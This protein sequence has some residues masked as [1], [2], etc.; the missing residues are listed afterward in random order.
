VSAALIVF[1]KHPTPGRAKTR[2]AAALG[3]EDAAAVYRA[4]AEELMRRSR[5]PA[6]RR[7][8]FFAPGTTPEEMG[9][10][11]PGEEWHA[12]RG[13]DLGERIHLAFEAAFAAGA[14]RAA[15]VGS[16]LPWIGEREVLEAL[17]ALDSSD[18][19]VGPSRDGGYYLLALRQPAPSLFSG[20][21]WSTES[22]LEA[23][24]ARARSAGLS[25]HTLETR[26]DV[27]T[28]EDLREQW[29]ALRPLIADAPLAARVE[30]ALAAW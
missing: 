16:D 11:L 14:R 18:V 6:Y 7:M 2:L 9:A 19:V 17:D 13:D 20:I 27:D 24:L 15:I 8:A 26:S 28:P 29:A 22:V 12:Q 3:P 21:A 25:V 30:E 10:W 23:T 5:S 4:L 1:L